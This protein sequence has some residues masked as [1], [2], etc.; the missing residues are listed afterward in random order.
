MKP[1]VLDASVVAAAFFPEK[2]SA[3]AQKLLVSGGDLCAPDLIYAELANVIWK[4]YRRREIDKS[5]AVE[6]LA[7][8][9]EL[10]LDTTPSEQLADAALDLAMRTGRTVYDC[11]YVVLAGQLK[12]VLVSGDRRLVNAFAHGPLKDCVRWLGGAP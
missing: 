4:R 1:V 12:A 5:E 10:P 9:L 7:D 11:L 2:H 8:V 3:A 6:L